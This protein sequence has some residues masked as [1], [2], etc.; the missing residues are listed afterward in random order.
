[1]SLF[2]RKKPANISVP[3]E[4]ESGVHR[5]KFVQTST[6]VHQK[7]DSDTDYLVIT[8]IAIIFQLCSTLFA[9]AIFNANDGGNYWEPL[10][11]LIYGSGI[12]NWE[13]NSIYALRSVVPLLPLWLVG[14][15]L[16]H[17]LPPSAVFYGMRL[18]VGIAGVMATH[19]FARSVQRAYGTVHSRLLYV[20][21][22]FF[23]ALFSS[24]N[25]ISLDNMMDILNIA[26]LG[27]WIERRWAPLLFVCTFTTF[28][29]MNFGLVPFWIVLSMMWE[30]RWNRTTIAK[31]FLKIV[32]IVSLSLLVNLLLFGG[33]D[34]WWF[35]RP[36]LSLVNH[37]W[38][39]VIDNQSH[40]F[41]SYHSSFYYIDIFLRE[42]N[43]LLLVLAFVGLL[44][45][46]QHNVSV[47]YIMPYILSFVYLQ[48][49]THK[50]E[51]FLLPLYPILCLYATA[52]LA[53]CWTP[54]VPS[55][56]STTTNTTTTASK[57]SH[58]TLGRLFV[59]V[60]TLYFVISGVSLLTLDNAISKN[61]HQFYENLM[62]TDIETAGHPTGACLTAWPWSSWYVFTHTCTHIHT[63]HMYT[64]T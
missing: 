30:Q 5:K 50:Q 41:G 7:D 20:I 40:W 59:G 35:G 58:S 15:V 10:H 42:Q 3:K 21:M 25:L 47:N 57:S 14:T 9:E 12:S 27:L 37:F 34:T 11:Y 43:W 64:H 45:F 38:F 63:T 36:T 53:L 13:W 56:S 28:L 19:M 22:T 52:F 55:H 16:K 23:H 17:F 51:R 1:M 48:K 33:M 26:A 8:G 24:F 2:H 29:R 62:K 39:N 6:N 18:S 46:K 4:Q 54:R 60:I 61:G 32:K 31:R 49:L 44:T